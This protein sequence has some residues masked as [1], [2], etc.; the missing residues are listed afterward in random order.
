MVY[1]FIVFLDWVGGGRARFP[2]SE[3]GVQLRKIG[4][5]GNVNYK[6]SW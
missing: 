6:V 1:L 3:L 2:L 5:I 4:G